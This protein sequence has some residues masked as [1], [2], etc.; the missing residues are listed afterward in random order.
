MP[1]PLYSILDGSTGTG[2]SGVSVNAYLL[3]QRVL[4]SLLLLV[5]R[6]CPIRS[7]SPRCAIFCARWYQRRGAAI[8]EWAYERGHTQSR[9]LNGQAFNKSLDQ[10][11]K[12]RER[13]FDDPD[14]GVSSSTSI[15]VRPLSVKALFI[16]SAGLEEGEAI[17][18]FQR[19]Q[20]GWSSITEEN[21][22]DMITSWALEEFLSLVLSSY[23]P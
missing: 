22:M 13:L 6:R 7:E 4:R 10:W 18:S 11:G 1:E 19:E 21:K 14:P 23:S 3:R 16:S 9:R 20:I 5:D 17:T 12:R 8:E 2:A 15:H